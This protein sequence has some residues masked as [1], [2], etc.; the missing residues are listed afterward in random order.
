MLSPCLNRAAIA[1]PGQPPSPANLHGFPGAG[2]IGGCVLVTRAPQSRGFWFSSHSV[3]PRLDSN[4][5][6]D[7]LAVGWGSGWIGLI[8]PVGGGAFRRLSTDFDLA[9]VRARATCLTSSA[10]NLSDILMYAVW[11]VNCAALIS[12]FRVNTIRSCLIP[13]HL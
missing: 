6:R 4:S 8:S 3:R 12:R 1:W 9:I 10:A 2:Q 13:N 11:L 5:A 7:L